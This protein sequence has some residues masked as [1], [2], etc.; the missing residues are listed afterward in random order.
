MSIAEATGVRVVCLN[1]LFALHQ[2]R[3]LRRRNTSFLELLPKDH[4][5]QTAEAAKRLL[6]VM[7]AALGMILLAPVFLGIGLAIKLTSS[8]SLF[9]AE[10]RH[11]Y[12]RRRFSM[13]RFRTIAITPLGQFLHL[14]P[15]ST[16][17][18]HCGMCWPA[19]CRW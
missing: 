16:G 12:A 6:D 7:G 1:D 8:G 11:G 17:C 18:R 14:Q 15:S 4:K 2:D 13:F 19:I 10:E 9:L 3:A 5:R